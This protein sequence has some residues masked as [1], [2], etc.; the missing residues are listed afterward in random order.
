MTPKALPPTGK[1]TRRDTHHNRR[2]MRCT[3]ANLP[4]S[5]I[6]I[7]SGNR[8]FGDS[9]GGY[10]D[11]RLGWQSAPHRIYEPSS[12]AYW[13]VVFGLWERARG[14]CILLDTMK[15]IYRG[16]SRRCHSDE[17]SPA[18]DPLDGATS[19]VLDAVKLALD[20]IISVPPA[21]NGI[22]TRQS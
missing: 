8:C 5:V 15:T 18:I 11:A 3:N 13:E 9:N 19:F 4:K 14:D 21:E 6:A 10:S 12:K 17:R 2:P 20:W 7:Y 1:S 16:L 22:P